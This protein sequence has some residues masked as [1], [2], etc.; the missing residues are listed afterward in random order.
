MAMLD[1]TS[2][3]RRHDKETNEKMTIF[4]LEPDLDV[5]LPLKVI[6]MPDWGCLAASRPTECG[7]GEAGRVAVDLRCAFG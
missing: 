6:S 7:G 2:K 4:A 1:T 5:S 3:L